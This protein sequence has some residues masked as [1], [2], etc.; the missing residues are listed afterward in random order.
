MALIKPRR[1][2]ARPAHAI[3]VHPMKPWPWLVPI[4]CYALTALVFLAAAVG[5]FWFVVTWRGSEAAIRWTGL[6]LQLFGM[7]TVYRNLRG[8]DKDFPGHA[9]IDRVTEKITTLWRQNPWL[10]RSV[11]VNFAHG[12][13]RLG[14]LVS[15]A[16]VE[17]NPIYPSIDAHIEALEKKVR[18]VSDR[19]RGFEQRVDQSLAQQQ[20]ALEQEGRA[21]EVA[22]QA[23]RE[24]DVNTGQGFS[25][26][27]SWRLGARDRGCHEHY[28]SR[29][30]RAVYVGG[31]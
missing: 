26:F 19:Q 18:E 4:L 27:I 12:N 20:T 14:G 23:I 10:R 17:N 29:G 1:D 22:D 5:A 9:L 16:H 15:Q 30:G 6:A 13:I 2:Y 31:S 24:T 28:V 8:I 3:V 21:R 7:W 11:S 25:S